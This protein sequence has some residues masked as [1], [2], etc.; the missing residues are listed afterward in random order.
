DR[1]VVLDEGRI[2]EDGSHAE[3]L[4]KGG[5]YADLWSRQS[6]GFIVE[7]KRAEAAE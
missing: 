1:L 6:G 3:L 4:A 7:P 2:V 5:L